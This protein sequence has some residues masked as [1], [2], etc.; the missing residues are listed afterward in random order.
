MTR[1]LNRFIQGFLGEGTLSRLSEN[2][3]YMLIC[4]FLSDRNANN[5]CPVAKI[6]LGGIL[7]C[8]VGNLYLL[9]NS[10]HYFV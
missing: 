3:R 8:L 6:T 10:F 5:P 7:Y 9:E 4:R 1:L 2:T